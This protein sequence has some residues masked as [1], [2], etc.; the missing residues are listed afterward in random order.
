MKAVLKKRKELDTKLWDDCIAHSPQSL[1]FAYSWYLDL[2]APDWW[3]VV[4]EHNGKYVWAMPFPIYDKMNFHFI[5]MP[6]FTPELGYF[7]ALTNASSFLPEAIR[8]IKEYVPYCIEYIGNNGGDYPGFEWGQD[9]KIELSKG[10]ENN[11]SR[12][13][14]TKRKNVRQSIKRNNTPVL[15]Q[16]IEGFLHLFRQFTLPKI[17]V[18]DDQEISTLL[19]KILH[20][21]IEKKCLR[22]YSVYGENH[23]IEASSIYIAHES[24]WQYF[25][26]TADIKEKNK[27]GRLLIF[28]Q[29]LK[30]K[31]ETQKPLHL[32]AYIQMPSST[33]A[34]EHEVRKHFEQLTNEKIKV[35]F[36]SWNNLPWYINLPHQIKKIIFKK[37]F[38]Y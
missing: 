29:F 24:R 28:S 23:K 20:I 8:L 34:Y 21:L 25:L 10:Y 19:R 15:D 33:S 35:P 12:F 37:V 6:L 1:L 30:E 26:N 3:G 18:T 2:V 14:K 13:S 4:V 31:T 17:G 38:K 9:L 11:I 5:K 22:I 36:T 7:S 16:N 32:G 27:H